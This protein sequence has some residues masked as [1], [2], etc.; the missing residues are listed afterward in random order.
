MTTMTFAEIS[1]LIIRNWYVDNG[2]ADAMPV[3]E[4][5]G[6]P[7]MRVEEL[8]KLYGRQTAQNIVIEAQRQ[9][10]AIRRERRV[11]AT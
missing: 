10:R 3:H 1:L 2:F 5:G 9:A 8:V 4:F 7:G 6:G 11:S